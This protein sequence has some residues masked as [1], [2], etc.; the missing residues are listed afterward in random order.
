MAKHAVL[1]I[2]AFFVVKN[3][4]LW[5]SDWSK[6]S[7]SLAS[8]HPKLDSSIVDQHRMH[9]RIPFWRHVINEMMNEHNKWYLQFR[10]FE[11]IFMQQMH[12]M[13]KLVFI[14]K[15]RGHCNIQAMFVKHTTYL[16]IMHVILELDVYKRN[17]HMY[18]TQLMCKMSIDH[19]TVYYCLAGS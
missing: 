1:E 19:T 12:I 3:L 4:S 8:S 7:K 16:L 17:H 2:T 10:Q 18:G 9:L 13:I 14:T 6:E 11:V 5:L 15:F